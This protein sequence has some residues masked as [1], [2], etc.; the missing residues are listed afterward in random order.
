MRSAVDMAPGHPAPRASCHRRPH[1]RKTAPAWDLPRRSVARLSPPT[2]GKSTGEWTSGLPRRHPQNRRG[3]PHHLLDLVDLTRCSRWPSTSSL[4]LLAIDD[5]HAR[6]GRCSS[7]A[8]VMSR[9]CWRDGASLPSRSPNSEKAGRGCGS[10]RRE[11]LHAAGCTTRPRCTHR[12]SQR[13]P[14]SAGWRSASSRAGPYRSFRRR[15]CPLSYPAHRRHSPAAQ[16]LYER[17]DRRADAMIEAGLVD[18]VRRLA[19]AATAG[20]YLR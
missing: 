12:L 18:E 13:P 19:D 15:N 1:G 20:I 2:P 11:A 3:V 16:V 10:A 17:I 5:I 14:R 6:D 8:P 4:L 7:A 9:W